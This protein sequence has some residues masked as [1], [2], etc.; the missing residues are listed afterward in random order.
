MAALLASVMPPRARR[1]LMA[2]LPPEWAERI[3]ADAAVVRRRRWD[4]GA[5]VTTICGGQ[6]RHAPGRHGEMDLD[7]LVALSRMLDSGSYSRLVVAL[8][9][10]ASDFLFSLIDARFAERV[11]R[12]MRDCPALAPAVRDAVVAAAHGRLPDGMPQ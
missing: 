9:M 4:S 2:S 8:G 3:E 12:D 10:D 1:A 7:R 11:R 6:A 5:L